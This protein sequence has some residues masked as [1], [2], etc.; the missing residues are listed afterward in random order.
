VTSTF[1]QRQQLYKRL[2]V[3]LVR[4]LVLIGNMCRNYLQAAATALQTVG[5][6][7]SSLASIHRETCV[8]NTLLERIKLHS[9]IHVEHE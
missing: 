6:A 7:V 1:K 8:E 5:D 3:P 4:W 2:G 9:Y